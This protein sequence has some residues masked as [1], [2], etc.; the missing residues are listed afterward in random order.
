VARG[1]VGGRKP[2]RVRVDVSRAGVRGGLGDARVRRAVR[3]VVRRERAKVAAISVTL[4]SGRRMRALNRW[5]FRRTG[6]TDVISFAL[7]VGKVLMG[8]IYVAPEAAA[9][10]AAAHGISVREEMTRLVVHG[11]LH[12]LGW[13]HPEGERRTRS[14]MWRRQEL[15]VRALKKGA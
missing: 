7:P 11:V 6:L 3:E 12:V 8:D 14:A 5:H 9:R 13:D 4:V 1:R 10:S 15:Y 2:L